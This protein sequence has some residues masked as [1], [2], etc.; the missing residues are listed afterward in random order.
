MR[1][2]NEPEKLAEYVQKLNLQSLCGFDL[3][4]VA[5]LC[6]FEKGE[7]LLNTSRIPQHIYILVRGKVRVFSYTAT[8]LTLT[9]GSYDG[10][11]LFGEAAALWGKYPTSNVQAITE[12]D[13]IGISLAQNRALLL[14][15]LAFM[16]YVAQTLAERL[17]AN[18][19]QALLDPF[20]VRFSRYLLNN[21]ADGEFSS[22]LADASKALNV[23]YRHLLRT[24]KLFCE[25]GYLKKTGRSYRIVDADALELISD[26]LGTEAATRLPTSRNA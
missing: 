10:F 25:N 13:C 15:D 7:Y 19:G 17:A 20:E 6:R 12:C 23:S 8:S 9:R 18:D 22:N 24:L 2:L 4:D 26:G 1:K 3:M 21:S 14:N 5:V 11:S 16:R